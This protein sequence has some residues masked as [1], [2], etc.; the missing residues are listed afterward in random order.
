MFNQ[1]KDQKPW[2]LA[3]AAGVIIFSAFGV[4]HTAST[5]NDIQQS[6]AAGYASKTTFTN[7]QSTSGGC[8]P[9]GCAACGICTTLQYEQN[10]ETAPTSSV[11]IETAF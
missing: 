3:A 8:N 5:Y 4:Y 1:I 7:A 6:Q 11:Q 2:L 9:L 10:E